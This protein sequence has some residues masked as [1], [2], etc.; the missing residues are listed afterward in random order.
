MQSTP[1]SDVSIS[2]RRDA[3]AGSATISWLEVLR[4]KAKEREREGDRRRWREREKELE[5][6]WREREGAMPRRRELEKE[7][8]HTRPSGISSD[9]EGGL[10]ASYTHVFGN[11][12]GCP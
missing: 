5:R 8:V 9:V 10:V 11:V 12:R 7:G 4:R 1:S 2:K 3:C 6:R